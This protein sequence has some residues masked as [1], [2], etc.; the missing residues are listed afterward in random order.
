MKNS[1]YLLIKL[2]AVVVMITA[3]ICLFP[4]TSTNEDGQTDVAPQSTSRHVTMFET[5]HPQTSIER[6]LDLNYPQRFQLDTVSLLKPQ[7]GQPGI[8]KQDFSS[9]QAVASNL[10]REKG[11]VN[12]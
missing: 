5:Q 10:H 3:L 11:G 12:Q 8:V 4:R 2:A 1:K 6:L 9:N 7:N